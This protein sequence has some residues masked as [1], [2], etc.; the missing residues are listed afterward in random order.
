[1]PLDDLIDP[2]TQPEK[3]AGE[4]RFTEG[5]VFSRRGYLLF[6]DI[7]NN[8]IHRWERGRLSVFRENSNGANGLTFDHQGRLLACE[9][10]RVTR[11]EKDGSITV[12]ASA[13]LERPN[14]LVY[15]IDG[16]IY[17]S[18]LPKSRVYQITQGQVRLAAD[19]CAAPNGV[20]LAP[21]QQRLYL[22]DSKQRIL[23]AYDVTPDGALRN[24]RVFAQ[25][26]GD[27]LKTDERGNVWVASEGGIRVFSASG[28]HRGTVPVPE[29]PS[30]C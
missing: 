6:S 16:S 23:R 9:T 27:G 12:L 17:F 28:E 24:S 13:G 19:D 30:N 2:K 25:C 10:G 14:D 11:T 20:A 18:D 26:R 21:N 22:A 15:A 8:R 7:P 1:M 5:P 4:F 29:Q 3:V